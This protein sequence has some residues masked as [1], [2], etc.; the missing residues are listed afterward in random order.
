MLVNLD[1]VNRSRHSGGQ[2]R[3]GLTCLYL[4]LRKGSFWSYCLCRLPFVLTCCYSFFVENIVVVFKGY[5]MFLDVHASSLSNLRK[6]Q[7]KNNIIATCD[8]PRQ[9]HTNIRFGWCRS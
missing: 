9:P 7:S 2:P 8:C 4:L 3:Q 5:F 1:P 6:V